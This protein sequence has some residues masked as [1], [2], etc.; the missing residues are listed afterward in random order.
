M[1]GHWQNAEIIRAKTKSRLDGGSD[2]SIRSFR[3]HLKTLKIMWG[4][5]VPKAAQ[6]PAS[7]RANGTLMLAAVVFSLSNG[8]DN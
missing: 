7:A 5:I 6:P 8:F 3:C 4:S 2:A 1:L